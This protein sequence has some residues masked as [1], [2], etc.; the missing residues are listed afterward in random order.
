MNLSRKLLSGSGVMLALLLAFGGS[1]LVMV[2]DFKADLDRA[3][4]VTARQQYLAGAVS[5]AAAEIPSLAR[6]WV[7]SAVVADEAHAKAYQQQFGAATA[8]L[9]K[10][11][12]ELGQISQGQ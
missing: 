12:A 2:G 11:L 3:V 1:A 5:T 4:N 9:Q 10:F 7:L 6:G 8:S